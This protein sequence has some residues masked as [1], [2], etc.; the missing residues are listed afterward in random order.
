VIPL[1]STL[2]EIETAVL[3][4]LAKLA[5]SDAPFGT[6]AGLQLDAVFQSLVVGLV[7]QVALPAEASRMKAK[8]RVRKVTSSCFVMIFLS[9]TFDDFAFRSVTAIVE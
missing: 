2:L 1:T 3:L 4:E 9:F 8:L 7:F 5:V 6:V